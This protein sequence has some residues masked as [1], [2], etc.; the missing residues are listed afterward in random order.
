M[1]VFLRDDSRMVKSTDMGL[2]N[3][4]MEASSMKESGKTINSMERELTMTQ[5]GTF[6]EASGAAVKKAARA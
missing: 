2:K 4:L 6:T 5:M 3:A 1:E